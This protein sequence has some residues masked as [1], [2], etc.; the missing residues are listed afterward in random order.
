MTFSGRI[1]DSSVLKMLCLF[2]CEGG[3]ENSL[4][5]DGFTWWKAF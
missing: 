2:F 5:P 1:L 3:K 4:V